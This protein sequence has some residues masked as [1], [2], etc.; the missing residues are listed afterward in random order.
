MSYPTV[1]P[2]Q[3]SAPPAPPSYTRFE[4]DDEIVARDLDRELNG[5]QT[6][7]VQTQTNTSD[8]KRVVVVYKEVETTCGPMC[9]GATAATAVLCCTIL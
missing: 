3:P 7:E 2:C 6:N 9:L 4:N 1:Y 5:P 8:D